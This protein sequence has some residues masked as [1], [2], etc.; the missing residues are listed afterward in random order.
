MVL[1]EKQG[2]LAG[3]KILVDGNLHPNIYESLNLICSKKYHPL[4]VKRWTSISVETLMVASPPAYERYSPLGVSLSEPKPFAYSYNAECFKLLR[5]AVLTALCH[6]RLA[7]PSER[8]YLARSKSSSN[9][10]QICNA[11]VVEE[12]VSAKGFRVVRPDILSF[13]EQVQSVSRAKVIISPIGAALA[14]AVFAQ[15]ACHVIVLAPWYE[16]ARYDYWAGLL[17]ALGHKTTFVLGHQSEQN[18]HPMH[19]DYSIDT[20][21]LSPLVNTA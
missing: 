15:P 21:R 6:D 19:R 20:S 8:V 5:L 13:R 17:M 12:T 7:V 16:G 4:R 18:R 2:L 9:L 11:N 1:Y 10:R 3:S 14:N